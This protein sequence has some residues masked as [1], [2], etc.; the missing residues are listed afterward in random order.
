MGAESA[1][2]W[3]HATFNPWSG[4]HKVSAACKHCYAERD[5]RRY[6]L[7]LWGE[8]AE[9]QFRSEAY[10]R[11]PLKWNR[12]A[13]Q[14]GER[15]RVFCASL[16][17]VFEIHAVPAT[18]AKMDAARAHL[19][20]LIRTTPWLDWLLLTKRPQNIVPCT[21]HTWRWAGTFDPRGGMPRNVWLGVTA[22]S[23]EYAEERVPPLLSA[24]LALGARVAFVSHEPAVG[25]VNFTRLANESGATYDALRGGMTGAL[26]HER[27]RGRL[28]WIITGGES[29]PGARSYDVA[30]ARSLIE[31]CRASGTSCFVKQL[32]AVAHET[33]EPS[34]APDDGGDLVPLDGLGR[35]GEDFALLVRHGVGV[36]EFPAVG[37]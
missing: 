1:I 6:G 26:P 20:E 10:W 15:R 32:G 25:P 31:Q 7:A 23:Q 35:K 27:G 5:T 4:C 19:W 8:R 18:N 14:A 21:P 37:A 9:R 11:A 34:G 36:R 28:D 13:E 24:K 12:D 22:E 3:T 33:R 17:D 29:G 30:W 16:A 2:A